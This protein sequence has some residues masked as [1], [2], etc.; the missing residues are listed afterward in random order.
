[1]KQV[2]LFISLMSL[3]FLSSCASR[4]AVRDTNHISQSIMTGTIALQGKKDIQLSI[5][6]F[7]SIKNIQNSN[8]FK[9]L[10]IQLSDSAKKIILVKNVDEG[11]KFNIDTDVNEGVFT[12]SLLDGTTSKVLQKKAVN[13]SK[14][15]DR[16]LIDFE[17]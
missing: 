6:G 1:M 16:I 9:P 5:H 3:L 11:L 12:I 7:I 2:V 14:S 8:N 10:K 17:I 13:V 4:T 15:N